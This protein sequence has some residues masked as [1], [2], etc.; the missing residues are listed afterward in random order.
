[1]KGLF[2]KD[3]RLMAEPRILIGIALIVGAFSILSL[4][5]PYIMMGYMTLVVISS[6]CSTCAY[7]EMNNGFEYIFCLPGSRTKYVLEKYI[8]T[9]MFGVITVIILTAIACLIN[10]LFKNDPREIMG[11]FLTMMTLAIVIPSILLPLMFIFGQSKS[12]IVLIVFMGAFFALA[13]VLKQFSGDQIYINLSADSKMIELT[14]NT[15]E[16]SIKMIHLL[17]AGSV[18]AAVIPVISFALSA[19]ALNKKEF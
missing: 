14:F 4:K 2:I 13:A 1:M 17:L 19:F 10:I 7:D 12:R 16:K 9:I 3:L 18:L 11:N 5:H 6:A 15:M 8:F